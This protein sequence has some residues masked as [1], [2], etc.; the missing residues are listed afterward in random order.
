MTLLEAQA[1]GVKAVRRPTWPDPEERIE[2]PQ[3]GTDNGFIVQPAAAAKWKNLQIRQPIRFSDEVRCY[4]QWD[5]TQVV[6]RL[7]PAYRTAV[8]FP[9]ADFVEYAEKNG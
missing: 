7:D 8:M 9:L 2:I 5:G 6:D 3:D 1:L 4:N